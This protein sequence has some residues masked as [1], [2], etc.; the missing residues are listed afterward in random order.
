MDLNLEDTWLE[1]GCH[2]EARDADADNGERTE[3]GNVHGRFR[4]GIL[5]SR[6]MVLVVLVLGGKRTQS[7][8]SPHRLEFE[9]HSGQT[10]KPEHNLMG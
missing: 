2:R 4:S 1:T 7:E 10:S 8:P 9:T 5:T 6:G 3:R